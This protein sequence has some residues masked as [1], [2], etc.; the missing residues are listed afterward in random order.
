[1]A[2]SGVTDLSSYNIRVRQPFIN[3]VF[4][5]SEALRAKKE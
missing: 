1:M 2:A 3:Q 4:I 5:K